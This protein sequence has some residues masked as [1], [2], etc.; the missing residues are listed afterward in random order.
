MDLGYLGLVAFTR[1]SVHG[2][3]VQEARN[4]VR[5][6]CESRNV[7][8]AFPLINVWLRALDVVPYFD[9]VD[10]LPHMGTLPEAR[11]GR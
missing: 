8:R 11:A 1:E 2:L 7:L 3:V 9:L 6:H 10:R 5:S 4:P